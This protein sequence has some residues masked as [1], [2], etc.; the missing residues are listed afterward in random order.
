M[1][2]RDSDSAKFNIWQ[3][4]NVEDTEMADGNGFSTQNTF[5]E[6][7]KAKGYQLYRRDRNVRMGCAYPGPVVVCWKCTRTRLS[8]W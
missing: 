8:S 1:E 2:F 3:T 7:S 4:S 6:S 5:L